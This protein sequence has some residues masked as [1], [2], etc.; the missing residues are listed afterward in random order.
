M[1]VLILS[2]GTRNKI[3]RYFKAALN[4]GRV[5]TADADPFAPAGFEADRHFLVPPVDAPD[6]P[7]RVLAVCRQERID[8]VMSLI[9]L[10]QSVLAAHEE[11]FRQ[12]GVAVIGSPF[13][14]CELAFDKLAMYRWLAAHGYR[15]A[16]TWAGLREFEAALAGG[17]IGFPVFLKPVRGS[18][19]VGVLTAYDPE[20][21][22]SAFAR[23]DDLLVQEFLKGQEIGADVYIDMISG[24]TVSIFTKKK[25]RMRAGETDRAV[26][27]RDARLFA[28]IERFTAEAGFRGPIDID[29]FAVGGEYYISEVNPRI[30]GGYPHA[31]ECGCDHV[32]MILENLRG[33]VNE[34]Q[35]G[36]YADGIYMM[37]YSDI[38]IAEAPQG[39]SDGV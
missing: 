17:G 10:E 5:V 39:M 1:N 31:H 12:E 23:R 27:F 37:K 20:T 35:T 7:E 38:V 24:E 34:K 33:N 11:Q 4:G 15:C 8:G 18:A 26:S 28:L 25:L 16:Q 32:R 14:Q 2:V 13:P 6:Y 30:G 36:R 19:S 21:V 9:D 3:V 22:R 29:L